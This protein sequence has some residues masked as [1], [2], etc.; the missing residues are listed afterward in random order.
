MTKTISNYTGQYDLNASNETWNLDQGAKIS[1]SSG[2]GINEA[3]YLHD[4]LINVNGNITA[5]S[6]GSGGVALQGEKSSVIVGSTGTID[7]WHGVELFGD[8]QSV[9]NNGTIS[10]EGMGIYS[11]HAGNSLINNGTIKAYM[12][13]QGDVDGIVADGGNKV[14]NS[15]T[16]DIDVSGD[17]LT[18]QSV[19]GEKTL[20]TNLGSVVGDHLGFYG[21][22]GDDKLVNRG[23]MDGDVQLNSGNDTFD[24]VGGVLKGSVMGGFGDDTYVIDKS[25][26]KLVEK[27]NDGTDSVQSKVTWTLGANFEELKLT[28]TSNING[29]GNTLANDIVGNIKAN[30]L[31]GMGG[32]D[33]LDGGKGNDFLTGGSG[34]DAFHFAKGY[35]RDTITDFDNGTD[36]IDLKHFSAV[37]DFN[38]LMKHHLTVSG[39]DLVITSGSDH[40]IIEDMKK[41][42]LD[43]HDFDF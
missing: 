1:S 15:K 36:V 5:L 9:V 13:A 7:A 2:H 3:S 39:H 6:N 29:K 38:D 14:I 43:A 19:G 40:L 26:Y 20:V 11:L 18:V 33:D 17:G 31:S 16:G 12:S 21:W 8:N 30:T 35:G 37:T 28:G 25:S 32:A 27:A 42:A 4:N 10:A 41:S 23:F 24:G 22:A 34:A